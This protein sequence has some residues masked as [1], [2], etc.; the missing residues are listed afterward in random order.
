MSILI[1]SVLNC[2]SDRLAISLSL[3]FLFFWSF[4]LFF[5]LGHFFFVLGHLLC[6][7][8]WSHRFSPG[9]GNPHCCMWG[10]G[11]RRNNG[12]CS[13]LCQ[14]SVT[15]STTH[16]L[17]GPF[18]CWFPG[19]RACVHCRSLQTPCGSLQEALLSGW[20]FLLLPPQAP[21]VFSIRGL[22]L[23]FPGLGPWVVQ[24]VSL[25]TGSSP[26]ICPQMWDNPVHNLLPCPSGPPAVTC[27]QVSLSGC[28]RSWLLLLLWVSVSPLTPWLSNFPTVRF[29]VSS[30][31]FCFKLC[32]CPT[33]GCARRYSVS[34]YASNLARSPFVL[35][36]SVSGYIL[37]ACLFCWLDF[38]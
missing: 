16:S 18:W 24:S 4:D 13:S 33:F 23:C 8:G 15:T 9:W 1:T 25:P 17:I 7:R 34:T 27:L 21:Q 3:N 37:L 26:F 22:R 14:F 11:S 32:C 2:A 35:K 6:S 28:S 12:A 31:C 10:R 30:G 19:W 36:F 38:T 5:H 29:S 20:E